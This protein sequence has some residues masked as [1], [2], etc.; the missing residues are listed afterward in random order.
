MEGSLGEGTGG[1]GDEGEGGGGEEEE[2]GFGEVSTRLAA[3]Y[4]V[5]LSRAVVM[6]EVRADK[7]RKCEE[8]GE[9]GEGE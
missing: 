2:A 6:A 3:T 8:E 9:E 4:L 7:P 5:L 1:G